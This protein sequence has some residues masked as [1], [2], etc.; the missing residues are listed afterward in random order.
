MSFNMT[1]IIDI[2]FLLIIFFLVVCQFIEAENFPVTVPDDCEFAQSD[3]EPGG[4]VTTV[5]VMRTNT[6]RIAF[7]VGS[8]KITASSYAD[9]VEGLARLIDIRLRNL[10]PER[11][12]VTLRVDKDICFGE[13][14]YALAAVAQSSATDIQL[15]TLKDK[16]AGSE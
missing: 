11:R 8:E 5:T 3:S 1:P 15:V 16:R 13:A 2:V 6:E 4:Q 9:I 10:P 7:A 12:V 14:Q